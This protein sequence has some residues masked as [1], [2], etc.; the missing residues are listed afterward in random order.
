[1]PKCDR[2]SEKRCRSKQRKN[3]SRRHHSKCRRDSRSCP[4]QQLPPPQVPTTPP[5]PPT[6]VLTSVE[7]VCPTPAYTCG[8]TDPTCPGI[9]GSSLHGLNALVVGGSRGMGKATAIQLAL[10]G[11]NVVATSRMPQQYLDPIHGGNAANNYPNN[12]YTPLLPIGFI[13]PPGSGTLQLS[14]KYQPAQNNPGIS[15]IPPI[16]LPLDIRDQASV[17][18][19]FDI[20]VAPGPFSFFN[21][22]IDILCI[23]AGIGFQSPLFACYADDLLQFHQTNFFGHLRVLH[24]AI[25]YMDNNGIIFD[26]ASTEAEAGTPF[27]GPYSIGKRA[28]HAYADTWNIENAY[29]TQFG[30]EPN[31]KIVI[32]ES[33]FVNTGIN[34]YDWGKAR[35]LPQ[36]NPLVEQSRT[37]ILNILNCEVCGPPLNL[38]PQDPFVT[39][40][41]ITNYAGQNPSTVPGR[42]FSLSNPPTN[43]DLTVSQGIY[44]SYVLPADDLVNTVCAD[45][46]PISEVMNFYSPPTP[47]NSEFG[48]SQTHSDQSVHRVKCY[49]LH[50]EKDKKRCQPGQ[51]PSPPFPLQATNTVENVPECDCSGLNLKGKNILVIGASVGIG[52][53]IAETLASAGANVIGT[54]RNPSCV[55]PSKCF[56][57]AKK[58][59]DI[60]FQYSVDEFFDE[61]VKPLGHIDVLINVAGI[62]SFGPMSSYYADDVI[63][64]W[65]TN[66]YGFHRTIRAVLPYTDLDTKLI[67]IGCEFGSEIPG[68]VLQGAYATTKR[69]LQQY[70]YQWNLDNCILAHNV[71]N[72]G[73]GFKPTPYP[74]APKMILIE[75]TITASQLGKFDYAKPE[76]LDTFN[77]LVQKP[78]EKLIKLLDKCGASTEEIALNV[79]QVV[80]T[81]SADVK[82]RYLVNRKK[83][84]FDDTTQELVDAE[85]TLP[86]NQT[87]DILTSYYSNPP[88]Q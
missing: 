54:S 36:N 28:Q 69:A 22:H 44:A 9:T 88:W 73:T 24:K 50:H 33:V 5:F 8:P 77:P 86:I 56:T 63:E 21:G 32:V 30:V 42:I 11:A 43:L 53:A 78:R 52:R 65:Q 15:E 1:M 70:A 19:F 66:F 60:R 16:I 41:V 62:T 35:T 84:C 79:L 13:F 82:Q 2:S 26:W 12:P 80:R 29:L 87:N 18:T 76:T 34:L 47:D 3:H 27:S 51:L 14:V 48:T 49:K 64:V 10:A 40:Q 17:D 74:I 68:V 7:P 55:E 83:N 67:N 81:P 57:L 75:P 20:A 72:D 23:P 85:W 59:M 38:C 61:M 31:P 4:N 37:E 46:G 25:Q 45:F 39:G 58:P 71:F 6:Q